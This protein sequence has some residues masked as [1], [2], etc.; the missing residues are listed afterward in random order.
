MKKLLAV[1][2]VFALALSGVAAATA[3]APRAKPTSG[4]AYAGIS[5]A[6]GNDLY[7]S[8]DFVDKVLGHGAIVYVT[9]VSQGEEQGE[10]T[11]KARRITIYTTKGS[12]TGKG[13]ATQVI[14]DDGSVEVKDGTFA[15]TKGTGKYKGHTFKGKFAG[16]Q[17]AQGLYTFSYTGTIK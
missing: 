5:H 7:V 15:L 6:E 13:Q 16:P 14:H 11:V 4:V 2:T 12:L 17:S 9:N 3:K 8:G 1:L 10:F